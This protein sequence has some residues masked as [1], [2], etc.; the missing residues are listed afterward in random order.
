MPQSKPCPSPWV[1]KDRLRPPIKI[2]GGKHYLARRILSTFTDHKVYVEPF[3][4]GLSVFLNKTPK[5]CQTVIHDS[6]PELFDLYFAFK[7]LPQRMIESIQALE[8]TQ[9]VFDSAKME[10][11]R[12]SDDIVTRAVG[13]IVRSRFS[14]GGMGK[15]FAW[16]DRLR[17]GKP[18][19]VNSWETY[20]ALLPQIANLFNEKVFV[21]DPTN[22]WTV[23][24][25]EDGETTLH[26]ADPPYLHATRTA[27]KVYDFE[28]S[29]E[30][31][32]RFLATCNGLRGKVYISGYRSE[33]Y[34]DLL[35]ESRWDR[36]E[37]DMPNH[38]GQGDKKQRRVEC[39]WISRGLRPANTV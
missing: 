29:E 10:S 28:M 26:Y 17:G 35:P 24:E 7:Y 36:V 32:L 39:L 30:D 23:M 33:M 2:H 38:S 14:R 1:A 5:T 20:K 15:D 12:R 6:N 16:S 8:Y 18:G 9:A 37:F 13:T 4:G 31:H 27:R 25:E 34:D 21:R 22:G 19:D 11:T 3:G